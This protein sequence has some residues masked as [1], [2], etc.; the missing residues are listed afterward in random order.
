MVMYSDVPERT[1]NISMVM[2]TVFVKKNG[3]LYGLG[4]VLEV[5]I[6]TIL[7]IVTFLATIVTFRLCGCYCVQLRFLLSVCFHCM[8]PVRGLIPETA[9]NIWSSWA[10]AS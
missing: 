2:E 7:F 5:Y 3:Y 6:Y 8:Y 9:W 10:M 1:M 4:S